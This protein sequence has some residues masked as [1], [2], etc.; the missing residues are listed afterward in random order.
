MAM[1]GWEEKENKQGV[2]FQFQLKVKLV[3]DCLY[4]L[5]NF[6]AFWELSCKLYLINYF[7]SFSLIF[8]SQL[9]YI[10]PQFCRYL[11]YI[12]YN[13]FNYVANLIQLIRRLAFESVWPQQGLCGVRLKV[14]IGQSFIFLPESFNANKLVDFHLRGIVEVV[15][16]VSMRHWHPP[17][18]I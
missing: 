4:L 14:S 1:K 6:C 15:K 5:P 13:L 3:V 16:G 11:V 8:N 7:Y 12:Q 9:L 17:F 10:S 2:F 18:L